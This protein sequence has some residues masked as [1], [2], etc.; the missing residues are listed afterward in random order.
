MLEIT[1]AN[2]HRAPHHSGKEACDCMPRCHSREVF[3]DGLTDNQDAPTAFPRLPRYEDAAQFRFALKAF[4]SPRSGS[5]PVLVPPTRIGAAL[6][7]TTTPNT[8]DSSAAVSTSTTLESAVTFE[9]PSRRITSSH[10][11][12]MLRKAIDNLTGLHPATIMAPGRMYESME[13]HGV[14]VT[15]HK[16]LTMQEQDW[17]K[18]AMVAKDLDIRKPRKYVKPK[19]GPV[20]KPAIQPVTPWSKVVKGRPMKGFRQWTRTEDDVIWHFNNEK[21]LVAA[22]RGPKSRLSLFLW[23]RSN[24]AIDKRFKLL[25]TLEAE[26]DE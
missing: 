25:K 4:V 20:P 1:E 26:D 3:Y 16:D 8:I 24:D 15:M 6:E 5:V 18:M 23:E 22:L 14:E 7:H 11:L 21:Y 19:L 9:L 13:D 17:W 2:L 10:R 12:C